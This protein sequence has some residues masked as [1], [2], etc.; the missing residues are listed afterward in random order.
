MT[1]ETNMST[2]RK[3]WGLLTTAE[4]HSAA[5]LLGLMFIGMLLETLGVGLVILAIALLTPRDFASNY[6]VPEP[7]KATIYLFK[8]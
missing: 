3:I 4:R 7:T 2:A 6:S 1:A 8:A 5:V